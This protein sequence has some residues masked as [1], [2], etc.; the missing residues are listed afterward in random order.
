MA[1]DSQ[2]HQQPTAA[3]LWHIK[4][5][6]GPSR[7]K[8]QHP[9]GCGNCPWEAGMGFNIRGCSFPCSPQPQGAGRL[10]TSQGFTSCFPCPSEDQ[11]KG[12]HNWAGATV[13]DFSWDPPHA[14]AGNSQFTTQSGKRDPVRSRNTPIFSHP[15]HRGCKIPTPTAFCKLH[16]FP[17]LRMKCLLFSCRNS[18]CAGPVDR[19][20]SGFI[21][22]KLSQSNTLTLFI[23]TR[24]INSPPFRDVASRAVQT[25]TTLSRHFPPPTSKRGW[26]NQRLSV[27]LFPCCGNGEEEQSS[28]IFTN[29]L[30]IWGCP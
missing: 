1:G 21:R 25:L 17:D 11:H 30:R 26:S 4:N 15:C 20:N 24:G 29:F 27:L 14:V 10:C 5:A 9:C 12:S 19:Y 23:V 18:F 8:T 6:A 16:F 28:A 13:W 22:A 3:V 7:K 2:G